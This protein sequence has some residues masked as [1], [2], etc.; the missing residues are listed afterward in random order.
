MPD[1]GKAYVNIIP[2]APG[3]EKNVEDMFNGGAGGAEKAGASLGKKLLGGIAALG[4]GKAIG[5]TVKQAFEAGGALQQSFGGLETIYGEAAAQAKEF[6]MSAAEAGISAN[7]YAEQAVSFGAA[8]KM[9]YGGD[10]QAAMEAANVAILDMA[11]NAAKMGTPLESIQ[12]AYQGFA[13]QNYTMLDNLKLG[14]GG[15]KTE[16]ERLLA[17][18]Q[19]LTGVKYNLDN[20]GD[21]YDAIH[22][23]QG[24]LGLTGVAA[25]EAKTTLTGSAGAMKA[26]WENVMGAMTTGEGLDVAMQ[27]MSRSVG[28]FANNVLTMLGN[29]APQVPGLIMGLVE[30]VSAQLPAFLNS[31]IKMVATLVEGLAEGLPGLV[32]QIP[33]MIKS[34]VEAIIKNLPNLIMG[35][36]QMA[37]GLADGAAKGILDLIEKV[38]IWILMVVNTITSMLPGFVESG[39]QIISEVATGLLKGLPDLLSKI[40]VIISSLLNIVEQGLPFLVEEGTKLIT[41]LA[42]GLLEG[43][44]VLLTSI[45][46]IIASVL[47]LVLSHLPFFIESGISLV[48]NIAVGLLQGLPQLLEK[49]P[50]IIEAVFRAFGSVNWLDIGLQIVNGIINGVVSGAS[51]LWEAIQNLAASAWQAAKQA[52]GIASPSKVMADEVGQWIPAGMAEGIE[53][54]L[55]PIDASAQIM[56]EAAMPAIRPAS[57]YAP[58]QSTN[59]GAMLEE[60]LDALKTM[61]FDFYLD[62]RRITDDVTIRQR[63][64]QR[65]GAIA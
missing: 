65:M 39:V 62:G 43:L 40:P 49:I 36:L 51:A 4:I 2:K 13:K 42:T 33:N 34:V 8:L 45:P 35:G 1:L 10:T 31:G 47:A 27:N 52:L 26:A 56:A 15:T 21:V 29:L 28:N 38:P 46:E 48:T 61:K 63:N 30:V 57:N 12:A 17:D 22:V 37:G 25:E 60:L 54:N 9:A 58:A 16:M 41:S 32:N 14:Y 44:P 19:A 24:E 50:E 64:A 7:S 53:D 55:A 18:A 59:T 3:I 5:D 20:L 11:D 6:A 23:I